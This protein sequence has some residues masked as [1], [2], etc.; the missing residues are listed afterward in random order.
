MNFIFISPQFP[1]TYWNW[2]DRLKKNGVNVLGIGDTPYDQISPELKAA[3]TEYYWL[4]S[5]EDY[6][7]VFRAV[8]FFSYKYGKIDW[9]ESNNEY[10]LEQ[11]AA[12]RTDFHVT[13]GASYDE[14]RQLQSKADMKLLYAAAGIPTAQQI[15]VATQASALAFIKEVGYPVFVKPE[16]GVG[17]QGTWKID[18]DEELKRFFAHK[19]DV[20][21]VMEEFVTGDIV[22]Y[23][24]IFDA[25]CEPLFENMEEFP[26]SMSEVVKNKL[27]MVYYC[28]PRVDPKLRKLGRA[29]G[30][31]FGLKSRFAHME[32]FRLDR[33]HAG[34]GAKGDYVGLEV[35]VRPPGGYTP[36]MMNLAHS[37]D[38]YQIWAD[39]VC[40][41]SR[42][43]PKSEEQY[44]AVYVGLRDIHNYVHSAEEIRTHYGDALR[45]QG[46]MP[47]G[48]A[49]DL[50]NSY[51]IARFKTDRQ[52]R[53]F[54]RF[55]TQQSE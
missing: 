26:P 27:D 45:M 37:V 8:A 49:D 13:T 2:C 32:F 39:M 22:S 53:G 25:H 36:D 6:E 19:P 30:K 3:L 24:A 38:V 9:I 14:M 31:S 21:Y 18:N 34:L 12:L 23:D 46:R 4:P 54:V 44:Y 28:R 5:L 55:V 50:G 41:D 40:S 16:R 17:A 48:L 11:D 42:L 20:P 1:Y 43:V 51:Y 33:D 15:K 29:A 35:N 10:W 7:Q 52:R 47:D